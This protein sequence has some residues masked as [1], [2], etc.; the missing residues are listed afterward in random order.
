MEGGVLS[1]RVKAV[2][3]CVLI[4]LL[5]SSGCAYSQW[6]QEDTYR[7]AALTALTVVDYSQTMKIAREPERYHEHNPLLGS[8]PSAARVTAHFIGAYALATA[9]AF[10]LPAPYRKYFQYVAIGVETGCVA[11]NFT[12]GLGF[13][14]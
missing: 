12:I 4:A 8:H 11:N 13:G 6:T 10:A 1:W 3:V 2:K 5:F 7:H 9:A 14:L